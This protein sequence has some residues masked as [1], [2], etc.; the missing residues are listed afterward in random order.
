[1]EIVMF[2]TLAAETGVD[3]LDDATIEAQT[4]RRNQRARRDETSA[5]MMHHGRDQ[6]ERRLCTLDDRIT[7][8]L[9]REGETDPIRIQRPMFLGARFMMRR[10]A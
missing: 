8:A 2:R 9:Q 4:T 10:K 6:A 1:M 7:D 3:M 5:E